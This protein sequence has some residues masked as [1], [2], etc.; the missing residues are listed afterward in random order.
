MK[1]RWADVSR[2]ENV[3][4]V[5]QV[6]LPLLDESFPLWAVGV[7]QHAR[8]QSAVHLLGGRLGKSVGILPVTSAMAQ[9]TRAL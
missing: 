2:L 5:P 7:A 9:K 6:I 8:H 3:I 4:L 1:S